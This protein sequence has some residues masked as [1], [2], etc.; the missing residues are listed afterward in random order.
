[1]YVFSNSFS[2]ENG[3]YTLDLTDS[4]AIPLP[5]Y[6]ESNYT[7][8]SLGNAHYTF[9]NV[10]GV[11]STL[12]YVYYS[13]SKQNLYY[14]TLTNGKYVFTDETDELKYKNNN[15]Y[16][17]SLLNNNTYDSSIKKKIDTWYKITLNGTIDE[18]L[19]DRD[20]IFCDRKY[21]NNYN[22][23]GLSNN[24]MSSHMSLSS[25]V[26]TDIS[27]NQKNHAYSVTANDD[28]TYSYY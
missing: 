21:V 16:I 8:Q 11:C 4:N 28:G 18:E 12:Y 20:A 23:W 25:G 6:M 9:F 1:M 26:S 14:T 24:S 5:G 19:I 27:C 17:Y 3:Q 7:N 10:S 15:N 22:G 2:Y 13:S